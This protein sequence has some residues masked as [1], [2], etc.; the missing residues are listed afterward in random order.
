MSVN[1]IVKAA[2][3][4]ARRAE[5]SEPKRDGAAFGGY[6][7]GYGGS[8][9][10]GGNYGGYNPTNGFVMPQSYGAWGG[11]PL[12]SFLAPYMQ[13]GM[14][15]ATAAPAPSSTPPSA[16]P[17]ASLY[18]YMPTLAAGNYGLTGQSTFDPATDP[19]RL[20]NAR[21]AARQK[22]EA[23]AAAAAAEAARL[24]GGIPG[25]DQGGAG[26][27]D[28]S[29]S[30]AA[31]APGN[32]GNGGDGGDGGGD[33]GEASGG[34]IT[35]HRHR[36]KGGP[37]RVENPITAY[38]GSPYEFDEFDPAHI[39]SGEGAQVYGH[40]LYFAKNE[41]V[42]RQYRDSVTGSKRIPQSERVL[43]DGKPLGEHP[44]FQAI[45]S[46]LGKAA[47][48]SLLETHNGD[49]TLV[50]AQLRN[51]A[52]NSIAANPHVDPQVIAAPYEQAAK[53]AET[54]GRTRAGENPRVKVLPHPKG[55]M[56]EVALHAPEEH[57]LDWYKPIV[58]QPHVLEKLSKSKNKHVQNLINSELIRN[59]NKN[60]SSYGLDIGKVTGEDVIKHLSYA[61]TGEPTHPRAS[62]ALAAAGIPGIKYLD[63]VSRDTGE[64]THNYVVFDPKHIET[65]R[66]YAKGGLV[67][68]GHAPD[69][70]AKGGAL[71][72]SPEDREA[73]AKEQ[74]FVHD[75]YHV[76]R[77]PKPIAKFKPYHARSE[78]LLPID[79]L[80]GI[81]VG[82]KE[83]AEDRFGQ[84]T[85]H[86]N[87]SGESE[88][89]MHT[90]PLKMRME[91]PYLHPEGRP[92]RES[93][94]DAPMRAFKREQGL[95]LNP[96]LMS[97]DER[98]AYYKK[99]GPRGPNVGD[100]WTKHLISQGYDVIPY[101]NEYE[102][103]G[104][105][106]YLVLRP[107]NLKSRFANFDPAHSRTGQLG[108]AEGGPIRVENP[109]T[110]YHG[111]A[112][113]H[114]DEKI[115]TA[116]MLKSKFGFNRG[117]GRYNPDGVYYHG[118]ADVPLYDLHP[119]TF[120]THDREVAENYL[121][122][123]P[124]MG[125]GKIHE[126]FSY[127]KKPASDED[128]ISAAKHLGVHEPHMKAI[129]HL[130][131]NLVGDNAH[132]VAQELIKRGFDSAHLD[133]FTYSG[134][135]EKK[136]KSTVI[137][138]PYSQLETTKAGG[139]SVSQSRS[140]PKRFYAELKHH[141]GPN[142]ESSKILNRSIVEAANN[143]EL[144]TKTAAWMENLGLDPNDED[145]QMRISVTRKSEGGPVD[146]SHLFH[147]AW[148]AATGG[149]REERRQGGRVNE[150]HRNPSDA[151]KSAGNYK[152]GHMSYHG[153]DISI[154][155]ARG[156]QRS[157]K[158]PSGHSWTCTLPA[159]YGYIKR[160]TGAD[161]DHVDVYI[162]PHRD[163]RVVFIVNQKD[164]QTHR[165]DEHKV[166]LGYRSE[167]EAVADYNKAFSDGKGP[168][169][170]KSVEAISLDSFKHWLK[171]GKTDKPA[172]ARS[173]IDDALFH[174]SKFR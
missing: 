66:R 1:R 143:E 166:M 138:D 109:I 74:G 30:D 116:T 101:I 136:F 50:A 81:H 40:G 79:Q 36:A 86:A 14:Q 23:D 135:N 59:A 172:N 26:S 110:A 134:D 165:F 150:P 162:G 111:H 106:S 131:E 20:A 25:P 124:Q 6:F 113:R 160:T 57:F 82:S 126:A 71:P 89:T 53:F 22:A 67:Y 21:F 102:D 125:H 56:Y 94:L 155:N 2:L 63:Q 17:W 128:V 141:D 9:W 62:K 42:A 168:H 93:E 146:N 28:S 70:R 107:E 4:L 159:D 118:G 151:Q 44:E 129:D 96:R 114:D 153:L 75:V 46:K 52:A 108:K 145:D 142:Y 130:T 41:D 13:S 11:P 137:F 123:G 148:N 27:G 78:S 167:K 39:G 147:A 115:N 122:K 98:E 76:T 83:A 19:S 80:A 35:G 34:R 72:M 64:S 24:N 140:N 87:V 127:S 73:R 84:V 92:W 163:S 18:N 173:I 29:G 60:R 88:P 100:M 149:F 132:R 47:L 5:M 15:G 174:T 54:L 161:G 48:G 58:E 16:S 10:G 95:D 33:G 45:S 77:S 154:E 3:E 112:P 69:H 139:G 32:T 156:S 121:R 103:A 31:S 169:R 120:F 97:Q 144:K 117:S 55:H 12:S 7:G 38:H 8:P 104:N 43:I 157:G 133:D 37:I 51:R 91:K 105:L 152:K 158:S 85:E 119:L 90:M 170:I 171:N 61:M 99:H 65:V 68:C 49:G 164:H